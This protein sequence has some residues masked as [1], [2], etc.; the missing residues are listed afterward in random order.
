MTSRQ[1]QRGQAAWER[2]QDKRGKRQRANQ[3]RPII[4]FAGK[5]SDGNAL[6]REHIIGFD[7][8]YF[9][10]TDLAGNWLPPDYTIDFG[11]F[12]YGGPFWN[13]SRAGKYTN[14]EIFD[15]NLERVRRADYVLVYIDELTCFGTLIEIGHAQCMGKKLF[16]GFGSKV[17]PDQREFWMACQRATVLRGS[18]LFEVWQ[19][20]CRIVRIDPR[21][22]GR[23]FTIGANPAEKRRAR[24]AAP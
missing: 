19:D 13:R 3:L 4:F 8:R 22:A 21:H 17:K 2:A 7:E 16:V 5:I 14:R 18:S 12:R 1:R 6:W 20:F 11:T 15:I 24:R 23:I 10:G 9:R